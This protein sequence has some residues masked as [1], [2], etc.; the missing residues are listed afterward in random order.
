MTKYND[1]E[2]TI[3]F[4]CPHCEEGI[5]ELRGDRYICNNNRDEMSKERVYNYLRNRKKN[6]PLFVLGYLF[7]L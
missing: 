5:M 7:F 1:I 3:R 6:K 2:Q 4:P